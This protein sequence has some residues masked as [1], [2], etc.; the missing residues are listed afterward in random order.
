MKIRPADLI[1][2]GK[3]LEMSVA[4][5]NESPAYRDLPYAIEQNFVFLREA[6]E[7]S[8]MYFNVAEV[9]GVL[10]GFMVGSLIKFYFNEEFYASDNTL[11]VAPDYRGLSIAP[12]LIKDFE[13][14]ATDNGALIIYLGSST[15]IN[16][17]RYI[18]LLNRLGYDGSG[19]V[20]SKRVG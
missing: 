12:R 9:D 16:E 5:K 6:V 8:T 18:T 14:W 3:V 17:E 20:V 13:R 11:Y 10:A 15:G 19:T 7:E 2:I 1:D 4:L